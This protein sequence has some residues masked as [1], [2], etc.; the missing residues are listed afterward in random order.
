MAPAIAAGRFTMAVAVGAALG[1]LYGFLRPLRR[2]HH[3]FWDLIFVLAAF[4]GWVY[5]AFGVCGGDFGA[6]C[7]F[8]GVLGAVAWEQT[9]GRLLRPV[10]FGFWKGI[11][12]IFRFFWFPVR[13]LMENFRIIAKKYLQ[14]G[15]NGLQ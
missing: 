7:F 5:L 6:F 15:R 3:W 12:K 11:G 8:G 4:A 2:K 9:V 1:L 14:N 13:K 10:F